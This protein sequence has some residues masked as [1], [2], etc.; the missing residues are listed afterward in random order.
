MERGMA[1][2]HADESK[3]GKAIVVPLNSDA[4]NVLHRIEGLHPVYAFTY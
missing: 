2:I 4:L 3:S 1:W